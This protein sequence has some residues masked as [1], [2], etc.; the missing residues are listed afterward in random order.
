MSTTETTTPLEISLTRLFNAPRQLVFDAWTK[1]EHLKNWCAPHG[2]SIP[3]ATGELKVGGSWHSCMIAPDGT[4]NPL[5]GVYREIIPNELLVFTHC[6]EDDEGKPE[7]ETIVTVKFADE[8]GKTRMTFGQSNFKSPQSRDGHLGGWSETF[9][10]FS[11]YLTGTIEPL[12]VERVLDAPVAVVWNA[13]TNPDCFKVWYFDIAEFHPEVGFK[14]EFEAGKDG[15]IYRHICRVTSAIPEQELA[16]TWTY[17]GCDE[18]TLVTFQLSADGDKTRL[19]LLHAGLEKLPPAEDF[20][21]RNF[22]E[23]WS[24]IIGTG[25][26]KFV[27]VNEKSR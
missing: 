22:L 17:A 1:P 6:W 13:L 8:D 15:K 2:Y 5:G 26:K 25:L 10:R 24:Y 12:V 7:H 9:E 18:D 14:F 20:D 4:K 3:E 23:G 27:E 19:K 16:Y 11:N 21:R